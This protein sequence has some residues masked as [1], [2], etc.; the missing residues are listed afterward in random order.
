MQVSCFSAEVL[1]SSFVLSTAAEGRS[2]LLTLFT[3]PTMLVAFNAS[4]FARLSDV[5]K[6]SVVTF[7]P[8]PMYGVVSFRTTLSARR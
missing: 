5:K 4:S 7:H 2:S 8:F 6:L 3:E 1:C